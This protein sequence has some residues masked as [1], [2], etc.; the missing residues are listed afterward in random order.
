VRTQALARLRQA[1][2]RDRPSPGFERFL[3]P[4]LLPLSG[5]VVL[6]LLGSALDLARPWPLKLAVDYALGGRQLHGWLAPLSRLG[7]AELAAVAAGLAVTL[8]VLSGVVGY[9]SEYLIG[10]AAER[11]GADMRADLFARLQRLSLRFHDRNRTGDLVNRLTSDVSR[12]QDALVAI[13]DSLLPNL[14]TLLGMVAV[15]LVLDVELGLVA[16]AVVPVLAVLVALS[17]RRIKTA[18]RRTRTLYGELA[19][20][21]TEVLRNVRAVQAFAREEDEDA[22]FRRDVAVMADS[23]VTAVKIEA[24]YA[25]ASDLVLAIGGGLVLWLGVVQVSRGELTLGT[26]LVVLSYVSSV[27]R[28]IRSLARFASVLTRGAASGE[29]LTEILD[30]PEGIAQAPGAVRASAGAPALSLRGVSFAYRDGMPAL[31]NVSLEVAP[32]ETVYIVGASGAGKSTLL[33]LLLRLYDPDSGSI[34]LGG[35]DLRRL[36]LRSLRDRIALV[37]QDAWILDGTIAENIAF[38]R[39][40]A[41]REEVLEAARLALVDEFSSELPDGLDTIVGEGGALLSGGERR[42][43]ALARAIVRGA[44]LLVLD[45]PT[46]GLDARSE[47]A[48]AA[49]LRRV[50]EGRTVIVVSHALE[51]AAQADRVVV[52]DRGR[53]VEQGAHDELVG[54]EEGAYAALWSFRRSATA[55]GGRR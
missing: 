18:Q 17:R 15:V 3:T 13:F 53:I 25:P 20:R 29:R 42:R 14:L 32:G 40:G 21:A 6:S 52:L 23:A 7:T 30:E 54:A 44:S 39:R 51:A 41:H 33:A 46:T 16:L 9:F 43:V 34:V 10:A 47:A 48:V 36:E 2:R 38:G 8:V 11:I 1:R 4:Y 55:P 22:R 35:V 5:S 12:V 24:R 26:L 19:S 27:Y 49:A 37:P 28:P 50:S 45:E 31:R